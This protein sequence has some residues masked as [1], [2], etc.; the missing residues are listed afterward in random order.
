MDYAC[1]FRPSGHWHACCHERLSP[2][3][4]YQ[5]FFSAAP[6]LSSSWAR[7]HANVDYCSRLALVAEHEV[8]GRPELIGVSR[9][10]A[11]AE[12]AAE[13]AVVVEDGWQ[14]KG[15]GTILI[16]ELLQAAERRGFRQF[17]AYVLPDNGAVL[18]LL[19]RAGAVLER[20][21]EQGVTEVVFVRR[22]YV[23][24]WAMI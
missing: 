13:V 23:Q 19:R 9:Y 2:T 10:E 18:R 11:T 20:R 7:R 3:T 24:S 8:D 14:R 4:R 5:R 12:D 17:R 6:Q 21:T 22:R 15:L 1:T 16:N